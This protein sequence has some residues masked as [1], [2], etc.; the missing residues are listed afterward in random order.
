MAYH[1]TDVARDILSANMSE[2]GLEKLSSEV[3]KVNKISK[4]LEAMV[5]K[6][7]S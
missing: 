1:L 6:E 5:D 2:R 4:R 3:A 7:L